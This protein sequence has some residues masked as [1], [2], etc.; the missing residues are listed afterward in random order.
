MRQNVNRKKN[1][2][3]EAKDLNYNLLKLS[4]QLSLDGFCFYITNPDSNELLQVL[5]NVFDS[6][7]SDPK[8][9]LDELERFIFKE[10]LG[11]LNFKSVEVLHENNLISIVPNTYFDETKLE[12]YLTNTIKLYPSDYISFDPIHSID[13]QAVYLPFVN[14]NNY[15]LEKFGAFDYQH[16]AARLLDK[17]SLLSNEGENLH[18]DIYLNL[19][20]S[21]IEIIV[22][23]NKKLVFFN[24]FDTRTQEDV[25]YY[26]LFA[27]EQLQLDPRKVS[28]Q[29]INSNDRENIDVLKNYIFELS[30]LELNPF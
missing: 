14:I 1:N 18:K 29:Y 26:T 16:A 11:D 4:I 24:N 9:L 22:F 30:P 13:A 15:I 8:L 5:R 25:V 12:L 23:E 2:R 28:I 21:S 3:I 20:L 10:D 27:L 17:L 7:K 19:N 6:R